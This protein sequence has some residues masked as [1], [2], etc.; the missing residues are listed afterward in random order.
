MLSFFF[1][2]SFCCFYNLAFENSAFKQ[3]LCGSQWDPINGITG[4]KNAFHALGTSTVRYGCCEASTMLTGKFLLNCNNVIVLLSY[5]KKVQ[6]CTA[7]LYSVLTNSFV[8][9]SKFFS[10]P[11]PYTFEA[12]TS[13]TACPSEL[14]SASTNVPNTETSC[15]GQ[16]PAGMSYS[17]NDGCQFCVAGQYNGVASTTPCQDCTLGTYSSARQASCGYDIDS[18]PA[19]TMIDI[20][21]VVVVVVY[22]YVMCSFT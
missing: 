9:F 5:C 19:G 7:K 14:A 13:C 15:N 12:S 2:P 20:G 16:C 11:G 1:P 3:T 17:A 4:D 10:D 18:C 8:N 21:V 22:I 6:V